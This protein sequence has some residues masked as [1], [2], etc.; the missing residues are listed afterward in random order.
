[1]TATLTFKLS[2]SEFTREQAEALARYLK[3]DLNDAGCWLIEKLYDQADHYWGDE[4]ET[5]V[6]QEARGYCLDVIRCDRPGDLTDEQIERIEETL[7]VE[8]GNH[9]YPSRSEHFTNALHQLLESA[10]R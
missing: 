10:R 8:A 3:S 6:E 4:D 1:M 7:E 2:Q 5:D 9:E